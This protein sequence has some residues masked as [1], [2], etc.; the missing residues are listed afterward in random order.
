V[1]LEKIRSI[2]TIE[3]F[4]NILFVRWGKCVAGAQGKQKD[5]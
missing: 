2:K 5:R 4:L 1:K 3:D